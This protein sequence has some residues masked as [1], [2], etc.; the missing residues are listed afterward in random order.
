MGWREVNRQCSGR[1]LNV[2][3]ASSAKMLNGETLS[4]QGDSRNMLKLPGP[5]L[6]QA[7]AVLLFGFN[8]GANQF[9]TLIMQLVKTQSYVGF[10]GPPNPARRLY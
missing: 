3:C 4:A 2:N 5:E 1:Q 7:S 6:I 10:V 9:A 8:E